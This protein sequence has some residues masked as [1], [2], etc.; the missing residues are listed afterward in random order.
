MNP[1]GEPGSDSRLIEG[2]P[3]D[4]QDLVIFDAASPSSSSANSA[5][6][7]LPSHESVASSAFDFVESEETV[8]ISASSDSVDAVSEAITDA[9]YNCTKQEPALSNDQLYR[10][11]LRQGV[12]PHAQQQFQ[13]KE[14][15]DEDDEKEKKEEKE[16]EQ[17]SPSLQC[18]KDDSEKAH[19]R[20]SDGTLPPLIYTDEPEMDDQGMESTNAGRPSA[21]TPKSEDSSASDFSSSLENFSELEVARS[22]RTESQSMIDSLSASATFALASARRSQQIAELQEQMKSVY[23][24]LEALENEWMN[25]L[26][27][28]LESDSNEDIDSSIRVFV[29]TWNMHGEEPPWSLSPFVVPGEHDIYAI[30]TQECE[31]S[32]EKSFTNESKEVWERKLLDTFGNGYVPIGFYTLM[33][34]HI[35]VFIR[36]DL[37]KHVAMIEKGHIATGLMNGR[38][39]NKGGVGISFRLGQTR[40]LF[41]ASHFAAHQTRIDDRNQDFQRIAEFFRVYEQGAHD[42]VFWCGDLN[43]RINGNRR[44]VDSLISKQYLEVL[45]ANDQLRTERLKR[46]VFQHF[47]EGMILFRPTYKFD[48]SVQHIDRYDS[49]K[50]QRVPAWTDRVLWK[51]SPF[52]RLEKYASCETMRNSD[53]RPVFAV[54]HV[55][56]VLNQEANKNSHKPLP[57]SKSKTCSVM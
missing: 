11:D 6:P 8:V 53:H 18:G 48:T 34:I 37:L 28:K 42:R 29:G 50:K 38:I 45:V 7:V 32:I 57:N 5:K 12:Q 51:T 21:S 54:F 4:D 25:V 36:A 19:K 2:D 56:C 26:N 44:A 40:F 13:G 47:S 41:V 15:E 3:E 10:D 43:Y 49:S 23:Q 55:D 27:A 16:E 31:R 39:G 1:D 24:P 9:N 17:N 30:G 33:A 35:G 52:I 20:R 46:S 22:R 14:E